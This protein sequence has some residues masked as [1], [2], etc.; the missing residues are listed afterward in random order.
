MSGVDHVAATADG[1]PVVVAWLRW[2]LCEEE[3]R[4]LSAPTA[5][6]AAASTS[7][8]ARTGELGLRAGARALC[9]ARLGR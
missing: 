9:C 6:S 2:R 3:R 7:R 4:A 1:L 8:A 5:G